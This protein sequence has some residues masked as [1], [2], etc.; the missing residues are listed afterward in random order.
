MLLLNIEQDKVV[1]ELEGIFGE[2]DRPLTMKD[3]TS[4][5]YLECCIKEALRLYPSVPIMARKLNEEITISK[6]YSHT[7]F[8]IYFMSRS[9]SK[10]KNPSSN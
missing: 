8:S 6:Y 7:L 10:T 4:M 3:L 9:F 5:K 2:E 1:Q